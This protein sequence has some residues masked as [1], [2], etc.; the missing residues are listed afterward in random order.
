M[1]RVLLGIG[2]IVVVALL[3]VYFNLNRIVKHEVETQGTASLRLD[4]RLSTAML[5]L[6]G[7]KVAL[8][9]LSIA[10]PKGFS[11]PHLFELGDVEV[12]VK[13]GE[14]RSHPIHVD[15]LKIEK[16]KLVVEQ[17]GGVLNLKKASELVPS[18]PPSK[19]P[20]LLV[21]DSVDIEGAQVVLRPGIPGL[22]QEFTITVPKLTMKD[23][24]RGKG[25][26]NGAAIKEVAMTIGSALAAEAAKSDQLPPEVR[27]L[28]SG[29]AEQIAGAVLKDVSGYLP[30]DVQGV[31]GNPDLQKGLE[32]LLGGSQQKQQPQ[33]RAPKHR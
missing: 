18:S 3:A 23:V 7:G 10:S 20:M 30:K 28:L 31:V 32:G 6:F 2:A 5:S 33:G 22:Q 26:K 14:L 1:K 24:G 29:N 16:P 12:A 15:L 8:H 19:D 11:A 21:I 25:A 4:T 17:S 13:Y 9:D 27:A